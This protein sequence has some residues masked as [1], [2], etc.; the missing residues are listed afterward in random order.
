MQRNVTIKD[1]RVCR[2]GCP[3][4][5]FFCDR[6]GAWWQTDGELLPTLEG[7]GLAARAPRSDQ[8]AAE[9]SAGDDRP[10]GPVS[11]ARQPGRQAPAGSQPSST[12]ISST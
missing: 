2:I 6:E 8:P 9:K 3:Q 7:Q 5:N 1:G 10:S 4:G 12:A 11:N